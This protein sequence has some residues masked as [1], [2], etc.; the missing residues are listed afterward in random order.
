[1]IV[2]KDS[3]A[4]KS[5]L[6]IIELQEKCF[7]DFLSSFDV[8]S[9]LVIEYYLFSSSLECGKQY[10]LLYPEE[11]S[12]SDPDESINGYTFYPDTVFATYNESIKCVGYHED[13]HILMDEQFGDIT[14]CF[15]KEGIA[16]SFDKEWWHI[17]NEYWAK[18]LEAISKMA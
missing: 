18:I 10:R 16:M 12:T 3:F 11:Y 14:S 15:V 17:K 13:V 7:E 2:P 9:K 4:K 8:K 5:I 1:M 6:S